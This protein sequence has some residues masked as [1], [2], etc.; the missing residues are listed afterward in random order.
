MHT[1]SNSK[2]VKGHLIIIL[3]KLAFINEI[4]LP[5][6]IRLAV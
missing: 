1:S 4:H 2:L 6:N 3:M 5:D